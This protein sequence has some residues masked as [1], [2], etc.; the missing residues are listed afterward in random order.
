L[1]IEYDENPSASIIHYTL[2]TPCFRD[3]SNLSMSNYWHD[4][5]KKLKNGHHEG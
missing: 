5:F 3:F 2:G 1:A 4:Y